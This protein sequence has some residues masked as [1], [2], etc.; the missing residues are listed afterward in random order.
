MYYM[1]STT[2]GSNSKQH[3]RSCKGPDSPERLE[4]DATP[5]FMGI[6]V[7]IVEIFF[8]PPLIFFITAV[9]SGLS[10]YFYRVHPPNPPIIIIKAITLLIC[11]NLVRLLNILVFWSTVLK[12]SALN[13]SCVMRIVHVQLPPERIEWFI[14]DQTF[15]PSFDLAPPPLSPVRKCLS[16]S[17]FLWVA[18]RVY[19]RERGSVLGAKL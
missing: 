15:F 14:E 19:W 2:V 13:L 8:L 6:A 16:F 18:G 5:L 9:A 17:V 3:T 12:L 7:P 4:R 1:V 11:E 10:C